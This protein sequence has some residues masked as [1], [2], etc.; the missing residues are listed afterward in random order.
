M[1]HRPAGETRR[2]NT[3]SYSLLMRKVT[4]ITIF[5]SFLNGLA[6]FTLNAQDAISI[7]DWPQWRGPD[8]SG[9]WYHG[10]KLDTLTSEL[11]S[12]IWEAEVGS[13]Y[14]GPT[15]ASGLVYVM[16]LHEASERVACFDALTG[17]KRWV[18]P[19]PVEYTV[20][21][22]T[23]PRA[24]VLISSGKAYSWG[25]MGHLHCLD[26]KS[27]ELIWK[28][29]TLEEYQ[30]QVPLWGLASNPILVEQLLIV[31]VSG[32]EGACMVAFDKD[33]GKEQ[34]RALKDEAS[35][36]SPI[37]ISQAGKQVLVCWTASKISGLDPLRG[38]LYWSIPLE[39]LKMNMSISDP[40]YEAPYLFL[41]AFFDGSY[42]LELDQ[43]APAAR[44]LYHRYGSNERNTDA[45]HCCIST[46]MIKGD[47]VYG[48]G[49]YGEAR[50]L[51]LKSGERLWEDLSLVPPGRW[52]NVH[53][54]HQGS[55]TW[56]F[57]ET[58]ELLLG[59]FTPGG[60]L[61]KGRVKIIEPVRISP[62]PRNGVTWSHPAFSGSYVF[63]RSDSRL[64]CIHIGKS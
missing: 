64:V 41:S 22:P 50:C 5:I 40:V 28:R 12:G 61:D 27:G 21:Y 49:S 14:N 31:Q 46:P 47:H 10:P 63:V 4:L 15:V 56:G 8:R 23:G 38:T 13:G 2:N 19:Y 51:D 3:C 48:I 53:L 55:Q 43:D 7:P 25:T 9:T 34:W 62:N 60:Y 35:Y 39:P 6:V 52:A 29:N 26:A 59:E 30:S 24:S 33:T 20:G 54:V 32:A 1:N 11:V 58:G 18:F 36:S 17:E 42:L 44:L 45:L 57:S 16:D 37:L